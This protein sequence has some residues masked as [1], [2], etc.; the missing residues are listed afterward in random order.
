MNGGLLLRIRIAP[1]S[2]SYVSGT[3]KECDADPGAS[4]DTAT[5]AAP[6]CTPSKRMVCNIASALT[7]R[8]GVGFTGF[9]GPG[10]VFS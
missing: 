3:R 10:Y 4:R 6:L 9:I 8:R 5:A 7:Q 2:V 1:S